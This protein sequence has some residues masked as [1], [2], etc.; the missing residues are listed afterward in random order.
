MER[1]VKAGIIFIALVSVIGTVYAS[2]LHLEEIVVSAAR[3]PKAVKELGTN[4]SVITREDILKLKSEDIGDILGRQTGIIVSKEGTLGANRSLAIRGVNAQQVLVMV[5]GRP[6]NSTSLGLAEI[7]Q[8]PLNNVEQIEIIR[9]AHSSLYGANA[10]GGVINIVTRKPSTDIPLT[11]IYFSAGSYN[12]SK[13]GMN[14]SQRKENLNYSVNAGQDISNGWRDNSDYESKHF[15]ANLGYN[16]DKIGTFRVSGAHYA[17]EIGIPGP[18]NSTIDAW[19]GSVERLS[20]SPNARQESHKQNFSLEYVKDLDK[21]SKARLQLYGNEDLQT[22]VNPDW[23]VNDLRSNMTRGMEVQYDRVLSGTKFPHEITLGS[24]IHRDSFRQENRNTRTDSI[25]RKTN[26]ASFYVQDIMGRDPLDLTVGARYDH[27]SAYPDQFN[28]HIGVL[29]YPL[30]SF[31]ASLN[32]ARAFRAPTFND[33]YW[34]YTQETYWGTNYITQGN[35]SLKAEEAYSYDIGVEYTDG[36]DFLSK[37]TLFYIT[38]EDMIAWKQTMTN[39]TTYTYQPQNYLRARTSGAEFELHQRISTGITHAIGYTY[40][41]AEGK[42]EGE[43]E[44]KLLKFRP[45]HKAHYQISYGNDFGFGV[46]VTG[47]YAHKQ[48]EADG[49]SGMKLPSYTLLDI[50]I[51]QK[52]AGAELFFGIDNITNKKYMDRTDGFGRP[53]PL[54]GRAFFGGITVKLLG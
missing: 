5:D 11:D 44:Y 40:L 21:I 10:V 27:H 37:L 28:P 50:R 35:P 1:F 36:R 18:S 43:L 48:F 20:S 9:G 54:P 29:W 15:A 4:V 2:E 22:Y 14:F 3:N 53:Y 45:H 33:L 8:I 25:S 49:L 13:L 7:S 30:Q 31:K 12:T 23:S 52:I 19:D 42:Q 51:T 46:T 26:S 41:H 38:T 39:S 17:D 6:V 47:E 34:P 16:L 24:D 32:I